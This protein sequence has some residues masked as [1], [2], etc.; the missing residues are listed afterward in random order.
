MDDRATTV[1]A[2]TIVAQNR[3]ILLIVPEYPPH[4]TGGGGVAFEAIANHLAPHFRR[5]VVFA[6]DFTGDASVE[7]RGPVEI[8]RIP[9]FRTPISRPYL[10][11]YLPPQHA[12][13]FARVL[14]AA[15][16]ADVVHIHGCGNPLCDISARVLSRAGVQYF[17]TNHG[18]PLTSVAQGRWPLGPL[19]HLYESVF[20]RPAIRQAR[21]VSAVSE[22]CS[23]NGPLALRRV[24]TIPNG[25]EDAVLRLGGQ[26]ANTK[27]TELLFVGRIHRDKGIDVL[28]KA[29]ER[30]RPAWSLSILG[31]DGGCLREATE[32]ARALGLASRVSFVGPVSHEEALRRM[33]NAYALVVPSL[34][35]PF[36]L[37]GLE[38]MALG[39]LLISSDTGGM[40]AYAN[41]SNSL[42]FSTG[43]V[44]AL[45]ALL[46]RLPLA[47]D[48]YEGIVKAGYATAGSMTWSRIAE[49]YC[50][51]YV[52]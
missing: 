24:D 28:L 40:N 43:N 12:S 20:T 16:R 1:V 41:E 13:A 7:E 29:L 42:R 47:Q 38:A 10:R 46:D 14:Q 9:L 27:K 45:A 23:A 49:S 3:T 50:H 52:S 17:Q 39:T 6:G 21:K 32:L 4:H 37:V 19:F 2:V 51:W 15:R 11:G 44:T 34:N 25:V 26:P 8:H 33:A 22:Y 35:E 48:E 5:T 36:G 18:Y 30:A 31:P